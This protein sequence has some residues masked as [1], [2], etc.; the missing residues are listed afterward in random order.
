[1]SYTKTGESRNY[2]WDKHNGMVRGIYSKVFKGQHRETKEKV[3]VKVFSATKKRYTENFE[4]L[5]ELDSPYIIKY[6]AEEKVENSIDKR[7]IIMELADGSVREE[8]RKKEHSF[9]LPKDP[10][11]ILVDN[12]VTGLEYLDRHGIA[13]RSIR[14]ESILVCGSPRLTFKLCDFTFCLMLDRLDQQMNTV[15]GFPEYMPAAVVSSIFGSGF[16][17]YTKDEID[18]WAAICCFFECATGRLPF[19][20]RPG[21]LSV[22][23]MKEVLENLP[24]DAV[25]AEYDCEKKEYVYHGDMP[26]QH[27]SYS[28]DFR[29]TLCEFFRTVFNNKAFSSIQEFSSLCCEI[30]S[31]QER[32]MNTVLLTDHKIPPG[33]QLEGNREFPNTCIQKKPVKTCGPYSWNKKELIGEGSYGKVYKGWNKKTHKAV[34]VK[35]CRLSLCQNGR[36]RE[37]PYIE[38]MCLLRTLECQYIVRYFGTETLKN[39]VDKRVIF[40]EL[41]DGTVYDELLKVECHYG[42]P[43]N[44]FTLLADHCTQALEYLNKKKV[45]HRDIKPENIFI[46]K[47]PEPVFKLSDFGFSL[48]L[49][50]EDESIHSY[51][52]TMLY[53]E[54]ELIH[55]CAAGE[56]ETRYTKDQLDL[57]ST[58]T[59][60]FQCAT[61]RRPFKPPEGGDPVFFMKELLKSRPPRTVYGYYDKKTERCV[62]HGHMPMQHSSYSRSFRTMLSNYFR[63]LF[64]KDDKPFL[65]IE[66]FLDLTRE[67]LALVPIKYSLVNSLS[68][69]E[70]YDASRT[71]YFPKT[72]F[73]KTVRNNAQQVCRSL[74]NDPVRVF[75]ERSALPLEKTKNFGPSNCKD[76]RAIFVYIVRNP[77]VREAFESSEPAATAGDEASELTPLQSVQKVA[78]LAHFTVQQLCKLRSF[79]STLA[80]HCRRYFYV[81][82]PLS[83]HLDL[84]M[85]LDREHR[86]IEKA[87]KVASPKNCLARFNANASPLKPNEGHAYGVKT[88]KKACA[89]EGPFSTRIHI[90]KAAPTEGE[91]I[92]TFQ[93]FMRKV[94]RYVHGEDSHRKPFFSRFP[95]GREVAKIISRNAGIKMLLQ[96]FMED[97]QKGVLARSSYINEVVELVNKFGSLLVRRLKRTTEDMCITRPDAL[98]EFFSN[99]R[100]G[101]SVRDPVTDKHRWVAVS[102]LLVAL[103]ALEKTANL[104]RSSASDDVVP[105]MHAFFAT[106]E[107]LNILVPAA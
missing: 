61:G 70:Y 59:T 88:L 102:A 93:T 65:Q 90:S 4:I 75:D 71:K 6:H 60:F 1:M 99:L 98:D 5:C 53:W 42:L 27:S 17:R 18:L 19:K 107:E 26:P 30:T 81:M 72:T 106:A 2:V 51:V 39:S 64:S 28:K 40:M 41:T 92:E 62:H 96:G 69:E 8:L 101:L 48:E 95:R 94:L 104:I 24:P 54:P 103:Y 32:I 83:N 105:Y 7:A 44:V 25:C 34:A 67:L 100:E 56:P 37:K 13:H 49:E 58:G 85:G 11:L 78:A 10:F 38:D 36:N 12:C 84:K 87:K 80:S 22:V 23:G 33:K 16:A 35:V 66:K 3:A 77:S 29:S 73:E 47:G 76:A 43:K 20:P 52:G 31:T 9:G 21:T 15:R 74:T 63:R 55:D 68:D 79:Y 57:W 97:L 91:I 45:A 46:C 86:H 50:K 89:N 82:D 14:P